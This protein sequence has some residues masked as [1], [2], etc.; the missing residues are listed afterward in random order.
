M[1]LGVAKIKL[2]VTVLSKI[3]R[4]LELSQK[5]L[6]FKYLFFESPPPVDSNRVIT[7]LFSP[8][9]SFWFM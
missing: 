7:H 5:I 2:A 1:L 4:V 6:E 8:E 3:L 9:D